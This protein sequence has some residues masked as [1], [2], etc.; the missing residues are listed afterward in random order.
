MSKFA[1]PVEVNVEGL[2]KIKIS[3]SVRE[4]I[5]S[6]LEA[7]VEGYFEILCPELPPLEVVEETEVATSSKTSST[8][9]NEQ[10]EKEG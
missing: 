3:N 9:N 10:Q 7:L 1:E 5:E 4:K 2:R 8:T 6:K